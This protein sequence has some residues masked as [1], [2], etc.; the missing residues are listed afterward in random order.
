MHGLGGLLV[1]QFAWGMKGHLFAMGMID[2]ANIHPD[3][4]SH[5]IGRVNLGSSSPLWGYLSYFHLLIKPMN[6]FYGLPSHKLSSPTPK[7]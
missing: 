4:W 5:K 1:E 6:Y 3:H 7:N 2:P